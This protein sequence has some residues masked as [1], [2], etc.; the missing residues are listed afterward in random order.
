[1]LSLYSFA[2]CI[3]YIHGGGLLE[4]KNCMNM[5]FQYCTLGGYLNKN[6]FSVSDEPSDAVALLENCE[7]LTLQSNVDDAMTVSD[8][9]T[10][11][12]CDRFRV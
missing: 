1:M 4:Q 7:H 9:L 2:S 6:A 8:M 3:A 11:L 5:C 12:I 10:L